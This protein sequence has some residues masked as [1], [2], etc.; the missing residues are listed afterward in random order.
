[1]AKKTEKRLKGQL[2]REKDLAETYK[3]KLTA[4]QKERDT[5]S[6]KLQEAENSLK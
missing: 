5:L 3:G 4:V 2:T 1:L 6:T